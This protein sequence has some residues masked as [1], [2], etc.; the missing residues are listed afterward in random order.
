M[1]ATIPRLGAE[2]ER[3]E[4]LLALEEQASPPA[5]VVALP[6]EPA[7]GPSITTLEH[8]AAA[9]LEASRRRRA[10]RAGERRADRLLAAVL[11]VGVTVD[12][13]LIGSYVLW[14]P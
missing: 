9:A 5:D 7:P 12:L 3:L 6:L 11:A 10:Q 2:L 14:G 4:G 1:T 13:A 8:R